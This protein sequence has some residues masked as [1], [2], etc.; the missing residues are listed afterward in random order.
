MVNVITVKEAI[1]AA[2]YH[3]GIHDGVQ[4]Y[5]NN[6][7]LTAQ[8]EVAALLRCFN[9]VESELAFDY[10]PLCAEETVEASVGVVYYTQLMKPLVRVLGVTD[11]WDNKIPFKL[12]PQ[13]IKTQAGVF[14]IRYT[15]SPPVK[16]L[17]DQ[18][19]YQSHVSVNLFGYGMAA[20][21]LLSQGLFEDA[22]VWDKK[23]KDAI[24]AIYHTNPC[25][26][27]RSRRWV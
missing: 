21:Y 13:C 4:A 2:A 25:R 26:V 19:S 5:L 9:L 16:E 20:E 12:F 7:N 6:T 11:E 22:A 18:S 8:K 15:Y 24:A 3:L 10:L 27:I 23:Y 1:L 14:K 17:E